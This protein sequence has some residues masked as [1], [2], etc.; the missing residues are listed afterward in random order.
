[1]VGQPFTKDDDTMMVDSGDIHEGNARNISLWDE[2]GD[3]ITS[4]FWF[5]LRMVVWCQ[6]VILGRKETLF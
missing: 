3:D 2:N 4:I 1:V 5:W 6:I